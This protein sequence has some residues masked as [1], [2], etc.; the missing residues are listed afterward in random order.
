MT[1]GT[2]LRGLTGHRAEHDFRV[3][4]LMTSGLAARFVDGFEA[5]HFLPMAGDAR[6]VLERRRITV[7]VEA[8][9]RRRTDALPST[10]GTA[11]HVAFRADSRRHFG[12]LRDVLWPLSDPKVELPRAREDRLPMAAVAF[13]LAVFGALERP[14]RITHDMAANTKIVVVLHVVI[15]GVPDATGAKDHDGGETGQSRLVPR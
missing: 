15:A 12:M 1:A 3:F 14:P 6:D 2:V 13:E 11:L 4:R 8:M 7:Q 5:V 10:V 9:A